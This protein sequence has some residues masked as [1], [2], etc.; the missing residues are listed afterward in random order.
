MDSLIARAQEKPAA[1]ARLALILWDKGEEERARLL[2]VQA[3][4]A[5]PDDG[6]IRS[7]VA[8]VLTRTV[9][10]WHFRIVRD[11][12]R[13]A[14][15]EAALKRA[16][17]PETRVFEIGTGT[18]ILAMMAA[19]AGAKSVVT[20]EANPAVAEAAQEIVALN[21]YADRVRVV[22][23]SSADL[24]PEV[25]MA[26]PAD[27]MVSEI[28]S[29][30]IIG[31]GALPATEH[32]VRS[33]L[34][35]GARIIPARGLVRVALAYDSKM[36]LE[37]MDMVDGFDLS[38]FNRLASTFHQIRRG[39]DRLALMGPSADLFDFDF[40]SGG[41]FPPATASVTLSST[42][43]RANGV[44]QWMA[45]KMDEE[46]WYENNPL[47]GALGSAWAVMFWPFVTPRDLPAG[48]TVEVFGRHDR[49]I[50]RIWA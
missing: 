35:P 49:K 48:A 39:D 42:G 16:V 47:P 46:E 41:P 29:N 27:L 40:Q 21:G 10:D 33:L 15:Y 3:L 28:V 30:T 23:K 36:W 31:E 4:R 26:G 44:A 22:A 6:E 38:P 25:D 14:A 1:L 7:L 45:L 18:G 32:A 43:G 2:A 20:C 24:D 9:P 34:R 13:N 12:A 8:G 5:A 19:R 17:S 11:A 50:L 37:R